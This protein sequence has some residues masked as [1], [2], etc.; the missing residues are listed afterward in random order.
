[1]NSK[2]IFLALTLTLLTATIAATITLT[3]YASTATIWTDKADYTPGETV[4]ISGA[5][6]LSS[7]SVSIE[8][9]R[10][11][12]AVDSWT[13]TSDGEGGFTTTYDLNG[14]EGTYTVLATDGINT[15]T[16]TFT[17]QA[18]Y[19]RGFR[20]HQDIGLW[21]KAN[22][23]PSEWYYE[24]DWVPYCL[25][26]TNAS[27]LW[28][29]D[30]SG[31]GFVGGE[32]MDIGWEFFSPEKGAV[33][34]DMI[35]EL[36]Y[37]WDAAID[38]NATHNGI[39]FADGQT[40]GDYG[41]PGY[42]DFPNLGFGGT[43]GSDAYVWPTFTPPTED[44]HVMLNRPAAKGLVD[45]HY[46][47]DLNET[48]A[49]PRKDHFFRIKPG[50]GGFPTATEFATGGHSH[51]VIYFQAHLSMTM[52]WKYGLAYKLSLDQPELAG[53]WFLG[54]DGLNGGNDWNCT[55]WE[56]SYLFQG[57]KSHFRVVSRLAGNVEIQI[58]VAQFPEARLQGRK[59]VDVNFD[60]CYNP[61][62]GDYPYNGTGGWGIH[63]TASYK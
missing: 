52:M 46:V 8:L 10:P 3:A 15:A 22:L 31:G 53:T 36:R 55:Y 48:C 57:A 47:E 56:G 19:W 32:S 12:S 62:D 37:Q 33:Y 14:I 16:T 28:T 6:F 7:A 49:D 2:I 26:I 43:N 35:G 17:D 1:L 25:V 20:V 4:V 50:E 21:V 61:L 58:P 59:I 41:D 27:K 34:I 60:G 44:G 38:S 24:D 9:T 11:D 13:V 40:T 5:G 45:N 42:S 51:I 54:D 23:S 18:A 29:G 63:G 39:P 30:V